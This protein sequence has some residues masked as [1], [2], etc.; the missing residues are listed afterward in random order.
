VAFGNLQA[1]GSITGFMCSHLNDEH[2][3]SHRGEGLKD[4][5]IKNPNRS[6]A[7]FRAAAGIGAGTRG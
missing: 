7:F 5:G 6:L 2:G 3:A 1:T 4:S